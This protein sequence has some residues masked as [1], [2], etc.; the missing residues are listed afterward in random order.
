MGQDIKG[1][2]ILGVAVFFIVNEGLSILENCVQLADGLILFNY[3]RGFI[4]VV[5]S[6]IIR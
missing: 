4:S 2:L 5:F 1:L 6:E 3:S